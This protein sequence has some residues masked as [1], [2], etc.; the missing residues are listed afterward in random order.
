M[1][2]IIAVAVAAAFAVPALAQDKPATPPAWKQ[3]MPAKMKDS[4]L[5]PHAGK[6]TETSASDI[7]VAKL[8]LPAGFKV[9]IWSTGHPGGRAMAVSDDGKKVYLGTRI[10]GRVYEV[11]DEGSKRGGAQ[12]DAAG[13]RR[14]QGRRALR[15]RDRQGAEVRRHRLEPER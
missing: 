9:E 3:G 4:K 6:M 8:K 11:T 2:T 14:L 12:A 5:A 7:P 13:G 10:I 15:V 1:K